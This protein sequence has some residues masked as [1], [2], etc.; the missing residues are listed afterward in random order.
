MHDM[1]IAIVRAHPLTFI[2]TTQFVQRH[3]IID[4]NKNPTQCLCLR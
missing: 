2:A 4:D 1:T 3:H